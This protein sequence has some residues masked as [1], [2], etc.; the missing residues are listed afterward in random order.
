MQNLDSFGSSQFL[1]VEWMNGR[2]L[3]VLD[4]KPQSFS[5]NVVIII[6]NRRRSKF[7]NEVPWLEHANNQFIFPLPWQIAIMVE[8][9]PHLATDSVRCTCRDLGEEVDKNTILYRQ[10]RADK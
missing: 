1:Y 2:L 9:G 8:L 4:L 5:I 7:R 3:I 6:N 10:L